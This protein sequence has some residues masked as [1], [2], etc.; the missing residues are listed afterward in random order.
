MSVGSKE[1]LL[2]DLTFAFCSHCPSGRP[3]SPLLT[4]ELKSCFYLL[5][6]I[7]NKPTARAPCILP[8]I[9]RLK[10]PGKHL[11]PAPGYHERLARNGD[12]RL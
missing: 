9:R 10:W 3:R 12:L 11:R 1:G 8:C 2:C 6:N 4:F 7:E 5:K